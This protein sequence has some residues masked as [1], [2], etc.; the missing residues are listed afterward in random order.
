MCSARTWLMPA[1]AIH[2]IMLSAP[3]LVAVVGCVIVRPFCD[4]D[5][6]IQTWLEVEGN[7]PVRTARIGR[8]TARVHSI[9]SNRRSFR[10]IAQMVGRCCHGLITRESRKF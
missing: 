4:V 3:W 9:S 7:L 1:Y 10:A 2:L 8:K 5:M 6:K